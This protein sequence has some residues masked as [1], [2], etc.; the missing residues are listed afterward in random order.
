MAACSA[1]IGRSEKFL[2][3]NS[4]RTLHLAEICAATGAAE[5]T[6]RYCCEEHLGMGPVRY[7][8]LRRLH[9]ARVALIRAD[10]AITTV[11]EIATRFEFWQ[12][13]RFAVSYRGLF[14]ESPSATLQGPSRDLGPLAKIYHFAETE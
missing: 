3:A 12:L 1:V 10:P 13:G 11:A 7:L 8:W 4:D 9:L 6:L 14:G 5:R 2:S